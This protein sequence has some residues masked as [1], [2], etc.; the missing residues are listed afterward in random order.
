MEINGVRSETETERE[1]K[2]EGTFFVVV[3]VVVV[4]VPPPGACRVGK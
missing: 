1:I 4:V 3:V 2:R